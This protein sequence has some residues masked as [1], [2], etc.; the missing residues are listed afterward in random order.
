MCFICT[1]TSVSISIAQNNWRFGFEW[2]EA[3]IS[4]YD[5]HIEN[6]LVKLEKTGTNGGINVNG[7]AA[8]KDMQPGATAAI[9]FKKMDDIVTVFQK[10]G[11]SLT[12][13]LNCNA[14]WAFP[15]KNISQGEAAPDPAFEQHWIDFIKAVVER[16]DGD[17]I[18]DMEGLVIPI[19]Y[20]VY[21]GEIVYGGSG[22]GDAAWGPYWFDTIDNLLHL[23]RIT[24]KAINEADPTGNTKIVS[25]GAVL[26]DLYADFPDYPKFDPADPNSTI[27]KRLN[28]ENYR[29]STYT[30]GWDSLKKMLDSFGNDADGIECDYI[31]WHPHGG[32][33][34]IDQEF[35]L[36]H[37]YAGN[38][39]I[40]VD[41]MW[42]NI[43]TVGYNAGF[44]IPGFAQFNAPAWPPEDHNWPQNL[45]GD[46]PNTLFP[47]MD[48][49]GTLFKGLLDAQPDILKWYY[50]HHAREIVKSFISAFGEGAERACLSG[51]NDVP[52]VRNALFGSI[53][54]INFLDVRTGGYEE[55]PGYYTYKLLIEKLNDFTQVRELHVSD[56][57]RT[58]VYAFLCPSGT[59]NVLWSETGD[60]PT[61]LDYRHNPTGEYVTFKTAGNADFV[62]L[63]HI[64]T[65][66]AN[67]IPQETEIQVQNNHFTLQLGY[68]PVFI[69]GE[70]SPEETLIEKKSPMSAVSDFD[71]VRNYPNP[72]RQSTRIEFNNPAPGLT[73]IR[74]YNLLGQEIRCFSSDFD[75]GWQEIRWDGLDETGKRVQSGLYFIQLK[76]GGVN[77]VKKCLK[78]K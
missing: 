61:D 8:W 66:T 42:T 74:I 6:L 10:H 14:S 78:I 68:E 19:R 7:V 18:D 4:W 28:G 41:D 26:F 43:P 52:E 70:I 46:F 5:P 50:A 47:G 20:Y 9:N 38:K 57:P 33:R 76:S 64:I 35:A 48:P 49:Y 60:A 75:A 54:W 16:Y 73:R 32:W 36:I 39:P 13:Y 77:C 30:A 12:P 15:S 27:Q 59:I 3:G 72:F 45:H 29:G 63:I 69:E 24:Y 31:G 17:G 53:G 62:K 23:H 37:H 65:D 21:T 71:L 56:D 34:I 11:F 40:H 22:R 55:K 2:N 67:V 51:T 25:A 58:R 1:L 44:S